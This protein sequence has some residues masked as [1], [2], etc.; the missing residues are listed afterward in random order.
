MWRLSVPAKASW[1]FDRL[2]IGQVDIADCL[3][4]IGCCAVTEIAGE[5]VEPGGILRLQV[6]QLGDSVAPDPL[7]EPCLSG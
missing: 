2:K 3:Q 7:F 1:R 6:C 4:G 5:C